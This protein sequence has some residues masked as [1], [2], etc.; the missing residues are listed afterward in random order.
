[1]NVRSTL[2]KVQ[3]LHHRHLSSTVKIYRRK[4]SEGNKVRKFE[5]RTHTKC[6]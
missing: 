6:V 1:M 5:E 2:K 4:E 3:I